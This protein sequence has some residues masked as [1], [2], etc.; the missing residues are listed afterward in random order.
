MMRIKNSLKSLLAVVALGI[1]SPVL[2]SG[3][4]ALPH[5]V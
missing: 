4:A 1:A 2:A 3:G 5:C